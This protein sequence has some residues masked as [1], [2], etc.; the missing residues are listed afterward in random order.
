MNNIYNYMW[1]ILL[2]I[3]CIII[4]VYYVNKNTKTEGLLPPRTLFTEKKGKPIT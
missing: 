3:F 2:A 1:R 4:L